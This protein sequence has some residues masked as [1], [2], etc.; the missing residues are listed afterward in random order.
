MSLLVSLRIPDGVVVGADSLS[1]AMGKMQADMKGK[2]QCP[3]CQQE[4]E[5]GKLPFPPLAIP[6]STFSFTQKVFRLGKHHAISTCGVNA[7]QGKTIYYHIKHLERE[8]ELPQETEE[9]AHAVAK[10]FEKLVAESI[11]NIEKAPPDFKPLSIHINGCDDEIPVTA[12]LDIGRN[13][14]VRIERKVGCTISGETALV[15]AMWEMGK[16]AVPLQFDYGNYSLQ[17]AIDHVRFLI[18]TTA[19][20]QRFTRAFQTVGGQVDIA[21]V[22]P[23][24]KFIWIE[25][26]ALTRRLEKEDEDHE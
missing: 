4:L 14:K 1:T 10:Y 2:M 3:K 12:T 6:M 20:F 11:P 21:A 8:S 16:K 17:D 9:L 24:G 22:T 19:G 13:T 23:N 7:L 18:D 15:T 26:K 25:V 5:I